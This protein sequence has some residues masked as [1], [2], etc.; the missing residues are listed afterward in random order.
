MHRAAA[1]IPQDGHPQIKPLH[2]TTDLARLD[3]VAYRKL[4][5]KDDEE[6]G[7]D[8]LNQTLSAEADGQPHYTRAGDDGRDVQPDLLKPHHRG[9]DDNDRRPDGLHDTG[10]RQGAFFPLTNLAV[11]FLRH[12]PDDPIRDQLQKV[13]QYQA[14]YY[15]DR[16]AHSAGPQPVEKLFKGPCVP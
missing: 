3:D 2:R 11:P 13:N 15:D 12:G 16:E 10:Q 7:D 5:L 8:I 14:P 6:A 1:E 4:S 9:D